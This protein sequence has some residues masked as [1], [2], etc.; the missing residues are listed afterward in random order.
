MT[1]DQFKEKLKNNPTAIAFTDTMQVIEDNYTFTPT[2]FKNGS[3][4]NKEGEN[5][6]SCKL[7]A[8]A[9]KQELSKEETL[10]CFGDY[11]RKDVLQDPEGNGH[12]N[13]RNFM[14][15]GFNGLVFSA[16]A[17]KEK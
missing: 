4:E 6:G 5:S 14:L 2:A 7:F 10:A 16:D 9:L 11:Y 8:F 12:L 3:L 17:L 1:L 15:T 13:I